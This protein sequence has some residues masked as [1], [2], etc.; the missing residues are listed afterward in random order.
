[1][2]AA[3]SGKWILSVSLN[4]NLMSTSLLLRGNA[5]KEP[6]SSSANAI[7]H[8]ECRRDSPT[9]TFRALLLELGEASELVVNEYASEDIVHQIG[10]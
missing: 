7:G 9:Q 8:P 1:M 3:E 10:R 2:V 4:Q 6:P 5:K